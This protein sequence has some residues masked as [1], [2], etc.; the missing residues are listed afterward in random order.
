MIQ[1]QL[2][3][4]IVNYNGE[5]FL[6]NCIDS[7]KK[8]IDCSHEIILVDNASGDSSLALIKNK[9][10][11]VHIIQNKTNVG[12]AA[13]NNIGVKHAKGNF[14]LLLNNDAQLTNPISPAIDLLKSNEDIGVLGGLLKY[15]NG[16]IQPS[17][18]YSHT[19]IRIV[20]S[21][22]ATNNNKWLPQAFKRIETDISKYNEVKEVEW[23]SGA[24]LITRKILWHEINSMDEQYFMYI[25]DVDFCKRMRTRGFKI[26][27]LS[28]ISAI[29]YERAGKIQINYPSLLN[30]TN[31]YVIYTKKFHHKTWIVFV[32]VGLSLIYILRGSVYSV[33]NLLQIENDKKNAVG[34]IYFK[35]AFLLL[36]NKLNNTNA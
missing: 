8:Y 12:F 14:L 10:P 3:I 13:G 22:L 2:S 16:K 24:F 1:P 26:Y 28:R 21:W 33:M 9:F 30:T 7:I 19:P 36:T 29:H 35:T 11:L 32:Q 20:F 18:G 23:V 6:V 17:Y 5:K 25:E 4:I 15:Q 34:R 31:S 27:F